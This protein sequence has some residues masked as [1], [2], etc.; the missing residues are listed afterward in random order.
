MLGINHN[1]VNSFIS[2]VL[3]VDNVVE[4]TKFFDPTDTG[5]CNE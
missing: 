2:G 4:H 3:Y 5:I 1:H